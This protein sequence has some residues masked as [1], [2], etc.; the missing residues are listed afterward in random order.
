[1]LGAN[2]IYHPAVSASDDEGRTWRLLHVATRTRGW[3]GGFPDI[4][5]DTD[6]ASPGYGRVWVAYNW[7][8]DPVTGIGMRV[9]CSRD[10]GLTWSEVEVPPLAPPV[11]YP[12]AWR[13]GY[14]VAPAP[15]G[16]AYV[17]G[18]QLDLRTWSASFPYQKGG[19][20]N[21]GRIAFGV[22]RVVLDRRARTLSRGPNVLVTTLPR[23][24]WN[25]GWV[26]QGVNVSLVE[27][28]WATGLVVDPGGRLF[29]AIAGDGRI[30]I[31]TSD[32][33][34][35][36]WRLSYLPTV[37]PANGRAQ[38]STRPDLV[39]GPGFVGVFLHTVDASGSAITYGSA[40]AFT[41]DR[42]ATDWLRRGALPWATL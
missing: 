31:L 26:L 38:R 42:G 22:A 29:Y 7:L 21:I 14:R 13:I 19:I 34:G 12:A 33:R 1:M 27:P 23:T 35:R 40:A 24:A 11:G 5:V 4:A 20:S 8:R 16:S 39:A 15:D 9:L 25:L 41:F 36:S 17:S 18:S 10:H 37:P 2:G 32:D 6:P 28:C 3:F 30:R